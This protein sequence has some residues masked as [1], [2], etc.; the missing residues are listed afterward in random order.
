[1]APAL[2]LRHSNGNGFHWHWCSR[3]GLASFPQAPPCVAAQ[4]ARECRPGIRPGDIHGQGV[5]D[6]P[7]TALTRGLNPRPTLP[8]HPGE[9]GP[10]VRRGSWAMPVPGLDGNNRGRGRAVLAH[11]AKKNEQKARKQTPAEVCLIFCC[12]AACLWDRIWMPSKKNYV[13][14]RVI[15][16]QKQCTYAYIHICICTDMLPLG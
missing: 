15:F 13:D 11:S 5:A 7:D 8:S 16:G 9:S 1:M 14:M 2:I 3:G 12:A 4:P 6:T 10:Y